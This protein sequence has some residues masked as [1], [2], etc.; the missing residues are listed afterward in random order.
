M[1]HHRQTKGN[2]AALTITRSSALKEHFHLLSGVFS[3]AL[4]SFFFFFFAGEGGLI[5]GSCVCAVA[6]L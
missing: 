3:S 2:E 6:Q 4:A 5:W 1:M